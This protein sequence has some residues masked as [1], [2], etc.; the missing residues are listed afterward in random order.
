MSHKYSSLAFDESL[1]EFDRDLSDSNFEPDLKVIV[2]G[3]YQ[4]VPLAPFTS[5]FNDVVQV[6]G[7]ITV[8]F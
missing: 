1:K 4:K 6:R 5:S 2:N 3:S 8:S 7:K